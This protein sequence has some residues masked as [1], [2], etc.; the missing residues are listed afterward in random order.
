M[1]DSTLDDRRTAALDVRLHSPAPWIAVVRLAGDLDLLTTPLL[2]H[3]LEAQLRIRSS[4]VVDLDDV[5]FVGTHGLD[6]LVEIC[7][8]ARAGGVELVVTAADGPAVARPLGLID[9]DGV[10]PVSTLCADE[11]VEHLLHDPARHHG[12]PGRP[13]VGR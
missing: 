2:R 8:E 9:A 3:Q 4:V 12:R 6:A 11:V 10:L 13:P 5:T 1:S 7:R